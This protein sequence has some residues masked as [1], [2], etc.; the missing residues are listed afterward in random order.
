[1]TGTV[2][3]VKSCL[4]LVSMCVTPNPMVLAKEGAKQKSSGTPSTPAGREAHSIGNQVFP[5]TAELHTLSGQAK[6]FCHGQKA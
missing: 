3:Q 6:I 1:M 2:N 5:V 4:P